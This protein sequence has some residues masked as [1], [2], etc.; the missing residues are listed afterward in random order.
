MYLTI[1]P[2]LKY[3]PVVSILSQDVPWF[4][5]FHV[6]CSLRE[7]SDLLFWSR[8]ALCLVTPRSLVITVWKSPF[9]SLLWWSSYFLNVLSSF[10]LFDSLNIHGPYPTNISLRKNIWRKRLFKDLPVSKCLYSTSSLEWQLASR[11]L[12]W[13]S[14]SL[15]TFFFFFK[16]LKTLLCC[17]LLHN[18]AVERYTTF[19]ILSPLYITVFSS[20][21]VG[22]IFFIL[23]LWKFTV[24]YLRCGFIFIALGTRWALWI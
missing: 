19:S 12:C 2:I 18:M 20:S 10:S 22:S 21:D 24:I 17:L 11:V 23:V 6:R 14:F 1:H 8:C 9:T 7:T 5:Q 16:I 3:L 13:K 4:C 15:V